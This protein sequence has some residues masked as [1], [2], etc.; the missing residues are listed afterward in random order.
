[1]QMCTRCFGMCV[2]IK[3]GTPIPTSNSGVQKWELGRNV[4]MLHSRFCTFGADLCAQSELSSKISA[5]ELSWTF[6]KSWLGM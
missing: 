1:M 3:Q 5:S 2:L 4:Y 6:V